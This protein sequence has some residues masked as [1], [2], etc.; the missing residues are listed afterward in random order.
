MRA[1]WPSNAGFAA[2]AFVCAPMA[3]GAVNRAILVLLQ[4]TSKPLLDV[5]PAARASQLGCAAHASIRA[6]GMQPAAH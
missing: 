4:L 1:A 3:D 6:R 5:M 2:F